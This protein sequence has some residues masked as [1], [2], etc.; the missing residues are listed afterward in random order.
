MAKP[1]GGLRHAETSLHNRDAADSEEYWEDFVAE[2]A[3]DV[4]W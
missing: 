2:L 1:G 4:E 3:V